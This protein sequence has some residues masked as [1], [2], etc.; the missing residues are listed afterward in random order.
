MKIF[1]AI[2]MFLIY[3]CTGCVE[4]LYRFSTF[5]TKAE[6]FVTPG[7]FILPKDCLLSQYQELCNTAFQESKLRLPERINFEDTTLAEF[8][9]N[10]YGITSQTNHT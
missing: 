3:F 6:T 7:N 2:L 5:E 9:R 8:G 1:E 4:S 10:N